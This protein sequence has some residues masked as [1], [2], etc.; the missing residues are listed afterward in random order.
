MPWAN[1]RQMSVKAT[2]FRNG[3]LVSEVTTHSKNL[4]YGCRGYVLIVGSDEAGRRIWH[5]ELRG[6][7]AGSVGDPF[8]SSLQKVAIITTNIDTQMA[9]RTCRM[10]VYYTFDEL[11]F[12]ER[13]HHVSVLL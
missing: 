12:P 13:F 5:T 8:C 4:L 2:L 3:T 7:T 9:C 11:P 1:G 6:K 10:D